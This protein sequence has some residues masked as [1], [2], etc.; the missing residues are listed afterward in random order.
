V[1]YRITDPIK[2]HFDFADAAA[3]VT[4]DLNNALLFTASHFNVDDALTYKPTE[5]TD[6]VQTRMRELVK[7]QDLGVT[8]DSV[9]PKTHSPLALE[10][11]FARV[12]EVRQEG[13]QSLNNAITNRNDL[14]GGATSTN[15]MKINVAEAA[16]A[17]MV[18]LIGAEQTN[19]SLL[20]ADYERNPELVKKLLQ[21]DTFKTVFGDAQMIEVLPN[22][23]G[24]QLRFHLSGPATP[25]YTSTN[26][27]GQ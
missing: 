10:A 14:V 13:A 15:A 17:R 23:D 25:L 5:F 2:F 27:A 19:F 7:D 4:N 6:A 12:A 26:Q 9:S 8:V 20:L 16:R 22:L 1:T 21:V 18:G 24:R 3:F 11:D